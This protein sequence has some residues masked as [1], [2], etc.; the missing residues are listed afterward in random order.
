MTVFET[1]WKATGRA[2]GG[3]VNNPN[4]SGGETNHGIT[5]ATARRA[6]FT[7]PMQELT[8]ANALRIAKTLYWDVM[9]L[10]TIAVL[11]PDIAIELFD[12]GFLMGPSGPSK[13]LQRTLNALNRRGRD[14]PDSVVDG[15]IGSKT[16]GA[17][18]A[19]LSRRGSDGEVVVL[20][21]LNS[22]QFTFLLDLVERREKDEDF[23]YGWVRNRVRLT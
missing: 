18:S 23:F 22:L 7:G 9:S 1:A 20:T 12:S 13:F 15:K 5:V 6:G 19:F 16:A 14:F 21:G 3:Y 8:P 10:D 17:L 11:S 2:E 4:D